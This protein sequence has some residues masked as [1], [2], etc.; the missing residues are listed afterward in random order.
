[1]EQFTN[2]PDL[3]EAVSAATNYLDIAGVKLRFLR[4]GTGQAI[5]ILHGW[6]TSLENMALFTTELSSRYEVF[7]VDLPGHGGSSLPPT[8]WGV[9]DYA[10]CILAFMDSLSI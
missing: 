3:R 1:M 6:G 2:M 4:A 7:A 10:D 5:V 9:S 8:A